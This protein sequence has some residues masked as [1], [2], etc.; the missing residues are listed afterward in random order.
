MT[1]RRVLNTTL[2]WKIKLWQV[3]AMLLFYLLHMGYY[4]LAVSLTSN[5]MFSREPQILVY[6]ILFIMLT[7]PYWWLFFRYWENKPALFKVKWHLATAPFFILGFIFLYQTVCDQL[8]IFR[9]SGNNVLWDYYFASVLYGL[10]VAIFHV[11]DYYQKLKK[12][13]ELENEIRQLA[14]Q[15]EIGL[16]KAQVQPH[17][18][19]NTLNSISASVPKEQEKTRVLISKLADT[20]RYA[21]DASKEDFVSLE[22]ETN[23]IKSYLSLEKERFTDQLQVK[24]DIDEVAL[25]A[26]IPSMLLQPLIENAIKHGISQTADGGQIT[27]SVKKEND[28]LYFEIADT[29]IGTNLNALVNGKGVGLHNTN[30]RL[31]KLY[32]ETITLSDNTPRGIRL[33]FKIPFLINV[34]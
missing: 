24:Y 14:L 34:I 13:K 33:N 32:N 20:F 17:F 1:I 10:S 8:S 12:Q 25:P 22:E 27:I 31:H 3:L 29:G 7:I 16:L 19:F 4:Y 28:W 15:S 23:F 30:L 26:A 5:H 11:Y 9:L 18:L 6:H 21:L 2:F